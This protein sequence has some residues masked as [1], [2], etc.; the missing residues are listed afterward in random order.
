MVKIDRKGCIG[1]GNCSSVCPEVFEMDKD[2]KAKVKKGKEKAK[3]T[4]VDKAIQECP[5]S[6]ISK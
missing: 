2:G 6:V 5:V 4:C 1:C 3:D